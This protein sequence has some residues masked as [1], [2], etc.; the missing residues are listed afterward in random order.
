MILA[1]YECLK[2]FRKINTHTYK[3]AHKL[4]ETPVNLGG[5]ALQIPNLF[6]KHDIWSS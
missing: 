1:V 6:D 5:G 4:L 2:I 3:R